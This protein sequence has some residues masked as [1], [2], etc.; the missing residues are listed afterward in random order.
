MTR[1]KV[2]R[3]AKLTRLIGLRI[4]DSFYKRLEDLLAKSNCRTVT[5]LARAILYREEIV[6]KHKDATLESTAI[7]LDG[8]R[9][10]LNAIGKNI[11]Q[12]THRFHNTDNFNLK[13]SNAKEIE[14]E[15]NK[16]GIRVDKL[17]MMASKISEQWLR[18]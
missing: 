10:E 6:W 17:L 7:A 18:E 2:E 9:R 16:V 12:I 1:R 15:Y 11:N 13:L 8:I 4:S 3:T 14:R 5:E